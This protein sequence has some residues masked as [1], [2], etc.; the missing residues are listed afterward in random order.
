M[1]RVD[2]WRGRPRGYA[3]EYNEVSPSHVFIIHQS[4]AFPVSCLTVKLAADFV[5]S[6]AI[7]FHVYV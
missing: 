5:L 6:S 7:F 1:I 2:L 4:E 3:L